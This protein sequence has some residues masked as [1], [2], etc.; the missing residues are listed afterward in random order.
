[1]SVDSKLSPIPSFGGPP[2]IP[3]AATASVSRLST[4]AFT[5]SMLGK[6]GKLL[7]SA[8]DD[9]TTLEVTLY[10]SSAADSAPGQPEQLSKNMRLRATTRVKLDGDTAVCVPVTENGQ[11]DEALWKIHNEVVQQART[12]RK[13]TIAMAI[14]LLQKLVP[15]AK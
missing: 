5:E 8:L 2:P 6:L 13:E 9:A 14:Q 10:T 4:G 3:A 7:G 15:G 1:M 12:D 11:P